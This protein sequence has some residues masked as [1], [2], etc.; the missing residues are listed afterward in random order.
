MW[1]SMLSKAE[2]LTVR[3][4]NI[5]VVVLGL[6]IAAYVAVILDASPLSDRLAFWVFMV[7]GA[8]Y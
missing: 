4:N 3:W 5:L 1:S 6:P 7:L 8:F 2:F